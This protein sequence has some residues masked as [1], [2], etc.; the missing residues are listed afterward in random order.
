MHI[1]FNFSRVPKEKATSDSHAPKTTKILINNSLFYNK[2]NYVHDVM[3]K[4]LK[5][6]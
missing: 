1:A 3:F 5:Y 6:S 4:Y 2:F